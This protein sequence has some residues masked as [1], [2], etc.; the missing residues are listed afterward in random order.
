MPKKYVAPV[1]KRT[2]RST[3]K[4]KSTCNRFQIVFHAVFP[5]VHSRTLWL[6]YTRYAMLLYSNAWILIARTSRK[7]YFRTISFANGNKELCVPERARDENRAI[8]CIWA[9]ELKFWLQM[10]ASGRNKW[11]LL[12]GIC[13]LWW[14]F[15]NDEAINSPAENDRV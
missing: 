3:E 12:E 4:Y 11:R 6:S 13:G 14:R 8:S 5:F 10:P 7:F 1:E 9:L 15:K 2:Q